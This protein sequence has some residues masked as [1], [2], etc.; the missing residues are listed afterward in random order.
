MKFEYFVFR[1]IDRPNLAP[2]RESLTQRHREYVRNSKSVL[3]IHGGPLYGPSGETVGTCLILAA[4]SKSTVDSWL[5]KAPFYS[6]GLFHTTTI[7][8][9]GWTYGR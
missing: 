1:G 6:A 2:L 5:E 8:H 4:P 9:W 7:D 3:M